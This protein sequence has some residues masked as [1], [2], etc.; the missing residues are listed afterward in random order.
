VETFS[1]R[2]GASIERAGAVALT[3]H[4]LLQ[5]AIDYSTDGRAKLRLHLDV[6]QQRITLSVESH[7]SPEKLEGLLQLMQRIEQEPD[8]LKLYLALMKETAKK[9]AGSGLGLARVRFEG[10]MDIKIEL[11]EG[12]VRVTATS[13]LEPPA[14]LVQQ[15]RGP[16]KESSSNG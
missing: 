5:N 1:E 2:G 6:P 8:P 4:E 12:L 11:A 13:N 3:V 16:R 14:P 7:G 10:G 15:L 9:K